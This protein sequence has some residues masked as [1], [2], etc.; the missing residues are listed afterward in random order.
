MSLD[1]KHWSSRGEH[2]CRIGWL[3]ETVA[4]PWVLTMT[5]TWKRLLE[6][7]AAAQATLNASDRESQDFLLN[8]EFTSWI[9]WSCEEKGSH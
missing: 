4:G 3:W 9:T 8:T 1:D 7:A 5:G 2:T 6:R